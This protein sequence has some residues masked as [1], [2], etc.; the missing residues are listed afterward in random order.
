LARLGEARALRDYLGDETISLYRE[1]KR[2]ETERLRKII[3]EAEY[4]W[5]L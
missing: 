2:I 3:S 1:T 4:D 5:Y